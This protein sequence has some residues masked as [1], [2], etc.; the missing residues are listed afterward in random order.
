M[1][2][3]SIKAK[4]IKNSR[5]E[6]SI[7]VIINRK[8]KASAPSGASTGKSEVRIFSKQGIESAV[9]WINKSNELKKLKFEEFNDLEI[10]D[11]YIPKLGGN[12]VIA[13]QYAILKAMS[14]NKIWKFLNP[15]AKKMPVPLGNVIGGGA[16]TKMVSTDIQEYLLIPH[17]KTVYDN[18]MLNSLIHKKIGKILGLPKKTDE[19]AWSPRM[20]N[21]SV[22]ELLNKFLNNEENTL[23]TKVDLGVDMAAS[24]FYSNE[25]YNYINFSKEK[26]YMK[27]NQ[28]EQ[29]NFVNKLIEDYDLKYFEDPLDEDD[30]IGFS[31]I[32]KNTLV[33]GDDLITTNIERLKKAIKNKSVNCMIIKPNQ[34]G[35]I[36]KT[37]EVVDLAKK[38][39][40][41]LVV[42]HRSG[43]TMDDT[44]SHLAVAWGADFLKCG[45]Y[46]KERKSKL[47]ELIKIE[48]EIK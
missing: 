7:S 30:F 3:R 12:P 14:K 33:C 23:G 18:V 41:K 1:K 28:K 19:G 45:I 16:H 44:I 46:G 11:R 24:S 10:I 32:S 22:F 43:E 13:I 40:I 42:S 36:I 21:I 9:E 5:G 48:S 25:K 31:K 35:S 38:H 26:N 27:F 4:I 2:I 6:D 20:D 8:Y 37:K 34:I 47:S 39:N 15:K 29:I 17:A